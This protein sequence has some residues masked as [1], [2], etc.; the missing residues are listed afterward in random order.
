[1]VERKEFDFLF[2]VVNVWF[3]VVMDDEYEYGFKVV[4]VI[5]DVYGCMGDL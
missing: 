5:D 3:V 4:V 1:M 2:W